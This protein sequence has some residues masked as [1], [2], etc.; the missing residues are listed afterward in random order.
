MKKNYV[1]KLLAFVMI[2]LM[3]PALLKAQTDKS[4]RPSLRLLRQERSATL[5]LLLITAALL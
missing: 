3:M 5:L 1:V 4:K 2:G